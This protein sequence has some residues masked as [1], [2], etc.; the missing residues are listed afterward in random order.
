MY[1]FNHDWFSPNI[2]NL[3]RIFKGYNSDAPPRILE[4]GAL[5]GM[6]TVWFLE[7]VPGCKVTTIDTWKGGKDHA[8]DNPEINFVQIKENFDYN[9][10]KFQDRLTVMQTTSFEGLISLIQNKEMYDFVYIDGS[11]TAV[12]AN[13]DLILSFKLLRVGAIMY[14]DDYLWGFNEFSIHD[15]PK[16]GIDSF[17]NTYANKINPL[18]GLA[19]NAAVYFKVTE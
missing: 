5:E 2:Q 3:N 9:T 7:N 16:L 10:S 14:C 13:L 11:H 6:S 15:C 12:D 17:V 18:I 4:I 8:S 1:K 19:N